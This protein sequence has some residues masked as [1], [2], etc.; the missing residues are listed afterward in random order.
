MTILWICGLP[1]EVRIAHPVT[2]VPSAAWSWIIGHLPPPKDVALHIIC[3]VF[4]MNEREAHFEYGGAQWHCFR[5]KRWEPLFLRLRFYWSIRA[6]VKKLKPDVVHGWGGESGCGLLATYCSP[7]AVVSVQ[8]ILRMLCANARQWHIQVPEM[9]S[10]SAWFRRRMENRTYR[11]A[12]CLLVESETAREGLRTLYGLDAE[13]VPY[14]LRPG[15]VLTQGRR[16]AEAKVTNF[17]FVGQMTARK[18]AMDALKA[19]AT[20]DNKNALL[21]MVGSGDLDVE[22]DSYIQEQDLTNRVKRAGCRSAGELLKLMDETNAIL[23]PTYGD[24]GPTILKEALSQG[25]YPI[26]YDNTGAAEL[27]GRY[28]F[29]EV[30]ATG[31]WQ[32]LRKAM[33]RF[34]VKPRA[35]NHNI[36]EQVRSDLSRESAWRSLRRV[37]ARTHFEEPPQRGGAVGQRIGHFANMMEKG[38]PVVISFHTGVRQNL[39][40][41]RKARKAGLKV[42][43]EINEWPLSV[44]W[45]EGWFKRW[46]EVHVLPKFFDG[47]ICISDVL[48]DFWRKHGRK[49]VPILKLPMTVDVEAIDK[50]PAIDSGCVP[51]ICYAGLNSETKDGVETLKRAYAL[52]KDRFP[53]V[54]L[55][56]LHDLPHDEAV[57]VMKKTACLVLARPNSLQARAGFPTKLGEYLATGR[58]VVVTKVGEIPRFL[59]DGKSAY[60]A[61]PGSVESIAAKIKEALENP[62]MA[63]EVGRAGREVA[64]RCFDWHVHEK[65][66]AEWL[67]QFI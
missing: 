32:A 29:G 61:E 12:H 6:F 46:F 58:P 45:K 17:L 21:T 3:P 53:N 65:E 31:D 49:G 24:T 67:K 16:D 44:T 30:C 13:V 36:A 28:A 63:D 66:L 20:M 11:R 42:V 64:L 8:G 15:F 27:V 26:C 18:G 60:L 39:R 54:E 51:Y 4:G 50:I 25:I 57:A 43:R 5:L 52:L 40:A 38:S 23:V 22:I 9:G 1:E 10:V 47:A 55:K 7:F 35:R 48:V 37:Y 33:D 56:L 14:P 62:V 59:E 41:V 34:C 2:D 19:F